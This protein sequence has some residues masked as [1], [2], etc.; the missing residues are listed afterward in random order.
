MAQI[1]TSVTAYVTWSWVELWSAHVPARLS[2]FCCCTHFVKRD[3]RVERSSDVTIFTWVFFVIFCSH[4]SNHCNRDVSNGVSTKSCIFL[5][6]L[7]SLLNRS[8]NRIKYVT[9]PSSNINIFRKLC[10]ILDNVG[11]TKCIVA[12]LRQ[13]WSHELT[14]LLRY[15]YIA[16]LGPVWRQ[17]LTRVT[18]W[19]SWHNAVA[20]FLAQLRYFSLI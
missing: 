1:H 8:R 9:F 18:S 5:Y 11:K 19:R 17:G 16:Y 7:R 13:Q 2:N 10:H 15:T 6:I 3:V 4:S 12:F 20:L 14:T